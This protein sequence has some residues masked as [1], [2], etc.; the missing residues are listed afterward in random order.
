MNSSVSWLSNITGKHTAMHALRQVPDAATAQL[1]LPQS[2]QV[3]KHQTNDQVDHRTF[4]N[5]TAGYGSSYGSSCKPTHICRSRTGCCSRCSRLCTSHHPPSVDAHLQAADTNMPLSTVACR[6]VCSP[7]S[8]RVCFVPA[9]CPQHTA[10]RTV[11]AAFA[12]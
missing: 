12:G 10:H 3:L 1:P 6:H 2:P 8:T 7:A 4:R 5:S 9:A 11:L